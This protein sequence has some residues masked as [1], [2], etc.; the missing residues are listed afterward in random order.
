MG[1]NE[2]KLLDHVRELE[3]RIRELEEEKGNVESQKIDAR[4]K[5]EVSQHEMDISLY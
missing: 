1:S 3:K 5:L 4:I 2:S